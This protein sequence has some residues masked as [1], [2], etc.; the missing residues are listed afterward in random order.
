MYNYYHQDSN[1]Q[2]NNNISNDTSAT[3]TS[4]FSTTNNQ[5][6]EKF[7]TNNNN[8]SN[9]KTC[10]LPT[11]IQSDC[12]TL[13]NSGSINVTSVGSGSGTV[14]LWHFIRE[15]LDQPKEYSSCVRWVN[16]EEGK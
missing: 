1:T 4:L 3:N 8:N 10:N 12:F 6:M 7:T 9:N 14:H 2:N 5:S 15:L 11:N 16:K 13:N